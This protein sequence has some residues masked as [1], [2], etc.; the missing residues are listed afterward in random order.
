MEHLL[1]IDTTTCRAP[2]DLNVCLLV[3]WHFSEAERRDI[4]PHA[5]SLGNASTR[6]AGIY[7][8]CRVGQQPA[9]KN[10]SIM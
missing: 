9:R 5:E 8:V 7:Q 6:V 3:S 2:T 10:N 4:A 1:R